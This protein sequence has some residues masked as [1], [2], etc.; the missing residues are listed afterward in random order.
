LQIVLTRQDRTTLSKLNVIIKLPPYMRQVAE[1]FL[2]LMTRL[3]RIVNGKDQISLPNF[4][5]M[6]CVVR[7]VLNMSYKSKK[8]ELMLRFDTAV[9]IPDGP[10]EIHPQGQDIAITAH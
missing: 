4:A 9:I 5:L 3:C 1:Y 6:L 10:I 8:I 2:E 7:N